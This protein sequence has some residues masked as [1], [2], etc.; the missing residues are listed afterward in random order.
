MFELIW[1]IMSYL[2]FVQLSDIQLVMQLT[3][4]RCT[5]L[6]TSGEVRAKAVCLIG[7]N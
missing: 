5:D 2:Q 3:S 6:P 4:V 1:V 7:N